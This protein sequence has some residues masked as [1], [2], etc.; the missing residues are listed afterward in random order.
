MNKY[1]VLDIARYTINYCNNNELQITNLKLQKILYFI[2][3][4]FL[5]IK[6]TPCFN[7]EIEAWDFGP[8]V[9]EVYH[10]FKNYGGGNIPYIEYY[11]DFSNGIWE[12]S[13]V[14]F[15]YKLIDEEDKE[16]I[17]AMINECSKYSASN[18][19]KLTHEQ[20]PWLNSF[21]KGCNNIIYKESIKEYFD[22]ET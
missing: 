20:A 17:N 6:N 18:L 15:D 3:A 16:I 4:A 14:K 2:Q 1:N 10:E 5:K 21:S 8:V 9:P 19:V 11:I 13:K 7:E 22:K 12:A